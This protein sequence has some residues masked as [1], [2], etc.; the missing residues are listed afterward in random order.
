M[1][2]QPRSHTRVPADGASSFDRL[3]A[4]QPVVSGRSAAMIVS[5]VRASTAPI[6]TCNSTPSLIGRRS[7]TRAPVDEWVGATGAE[8]T[9][10][11]VTGAELTGAE[12]TGAGALGVGATPTDGFASGRRSNTRV[13]RVDV[14]WVG[15]KP[16]RSSGSGTPAIRYR[17]SRESPSRRA[18][19]A[20]IAR[21]HGG[22]HQNAL[23]ERDESAPTGKRWEV[24]FSQYSPKPTRWDFDLVGERPNRPHGSS[25]ARL[26]ANS[27]D[28]WP[29]ETSGSRQ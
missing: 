25:L 26:R 1:T 28:R 6:A 4:D 13:E 19:N 5:S 2:E 14:G 3:P 20:L 18:L 29:D 27:P 9:G 22:E 21:L 12:V 24:G 7:H 16:S 15:G 10:A 11:E 17:C 23:I 8:A